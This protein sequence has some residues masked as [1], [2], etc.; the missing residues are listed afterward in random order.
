MIANKRTNRSILRH[1][2]LTVP[3]L[4]E[5]ARWKQGG[6]YTRLGNQEAAS[7]EY[8]IVRDFD[9]VDG[10]K[11][12]IFSVKFGDGFSYVKCLLGGPAGKVIHVADRFL[13][14]VIGLGF[15]RLLW[16][17]QYLSQVLQRNETYPK[18]ME[19]IAAYSK[20]GSTH[21]VEATQPY[22]IR[23][24]CDGHRHDVSAKRAHRIT[25]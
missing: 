7:S 23:S 5:A 4:G 3:G 12:E 22:L 19:F 1:R 15:I 21:I 10:D 25:K 17:S 2:F 8:H 14:D 13:Y 11:I 16:K 9:P 18:A 6:H 20:Q 24:I